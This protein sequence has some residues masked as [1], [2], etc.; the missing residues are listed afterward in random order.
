MPHTLAQ[1]KKGQMPQVL[2]D[3][4]GPFSLA[5]HDDHVAMLAQAGEYDVFGHRFEVAP[6]MYHPHPW[7]SSVFMVRT[8]LR[9]RPALGHLLEI[10]CGSG[11]VGLSLL[12]H[13]LATGLVMTDIHPES[14]ETALRNA[15]KLGLAERSMV[16][17]GSLFEPVCGERFDSIVFNMPLMH[18]EHEG[19]SHQAL[20]DPRG[21]LAKSFVNQAAA[22]LTSEGC[23]YITFSN[24]SE[25]ALLAL[26]AERG[27]LILLAAEWVVETGF[28]LMVY[29]FKPRPFVDAGVANAR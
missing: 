4:L 25:P 6:G 16:R 22:H 23:A 11:A 12:A 10:G 27:Q 29:Q 17:L 1:L 18:N 28:W 24:L 20:D 3:E 5:A 7:S 26:F 2:R 13:G 8:F 21:A 9:H 19:R 14:V 15:E